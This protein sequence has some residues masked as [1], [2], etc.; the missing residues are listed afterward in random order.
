MGTQKVQR[1][2]G[3]YVYLADQRLVSLWITSSPND[4]PDS[5]TMM[6]TGSNESLHRIVRSSYILQWMMVMDMDDA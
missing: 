6:T 2:R 3:T 1:S 4:L 5:K